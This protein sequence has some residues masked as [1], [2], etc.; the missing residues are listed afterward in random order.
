MSVASRRRAAVAAAGILLIGGLAACSD[1]APSISQG[2]DTASAATGSASSPS[3]SASQDDSSTTAP[4]SPSASSPASTTVSGSRSERVKLCG[5]EDADTAQKVCRTNSSTIKGN[6]VYCSAELPSDI[7]GSVRA[8]LFR[9]GAPIYEGSVDRTSTVGSLFLNFSVGKLELAGGDYTCRFKAGEDTWV[10][11]AK[12]SGP[13][14]RAS[15]GMAC[16]SAEMYSQDQVTHCT[17]NKSTLESPSGLGC[18]ALITDLM[19]RKVDATLNVPG[20]DSKDV[21]LSPSYTSGAAVV[22]LKAPPTAF[23]GTFPKGGYRCDFKVDDETV[24]SVPFTVK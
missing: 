24:I 13:K 2:S 1:D 11:E 14:G 12:V 16:D 20:G 21:S 10:G 18:S 19:G 6:I 22:H 3:E 23:G 17:T 8:S 15:Q 5:A 4:T 9:N 7:R